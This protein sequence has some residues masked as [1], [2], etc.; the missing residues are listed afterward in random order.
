[1]YLLGYDIGSS[2]VK[3]ALVDAKTRAVID[4]VKYPE[5]EMEIMSRQKGWAEQ[6]PE[7]W[8]RYLCIGTKSILEKN[9]IDAASIESIGISYQMHGLVVV[10]KE[11]QVLR[12]AI[13][14]CDSRAV[15]IGNR[16]FEQMGPDFCLS[17]YQNSPGNFTASKIKW[18]KDN[19]PD[20]Y[21][22][23]YKV[24]LP[25][26]YIAMKL[27]GRISTT[28]SGLSEGILWNFKENRIA[29][30]LL[31]HY[32][33]QHDLIPEVLPTFSQSGKLTA[34]ASKETG[35]SENTIVTYRAGDQPNNALSL[36]VLRPGEVAATSGT[37]GV[38]YGVVDKIVVD[39][40][41]RVNA[42]A[43]VNYSD[44]TKRTGVLLCINGAGIQYSWLKNQVARSNRSYEDMERMVSTVPVGSEG[45][46]MFPYGNGAERIFNNRNLESHILNVEF[47]RH[48]RAH[49]YRAALEG[50]AF[51]FV[52]GIH[53][54]IEMGIK[55]NKMRVGNDNM[56]RSEVFSTTI[57][58]LLNIDL[59]V[60]DTTG[61]VG[62]AL[63]SGHGSGRYDSL[64]SV[65]SSIEPIRTF[66]PAHNHAEYSQAYRF[67]EDNLYNIIN[68][69]SRGKELESQE[70]TEKNKLIAK[71]SLL[72]EEQDRKLN[73]V[74]RGLQ[75]LKTDYNSKDITLMISGLERNVKRVEEISN[76]I[77]LLDNPYIDNL[78]ST[79]P[80]L[81]F[82]ELKMCNFLKLRFTTKEIAEKLS[83]SYRGAE[84]KRYRLRKKMN[85]NKG[86][87]LFT[88]LDS[89]GSK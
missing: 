35:L 43:H 28:I 42:F 23:I 49:L 77:D 20:T 26:D 60:Y 78:K 71:Q 74:I 50:I 33:I 9:N 5:Q 36:N 55:V 7:L 65:L 81:S 30:K 57:A 53:I 4:V 62:A 87:S 72:I 16:A 51:T 84:T 1:M 59:E 21:R 41:S 38:V 39:E 12:P 86:V 24:M 69:T 13:I 10:N 47:N 70:I 82:E 76:H 80:D 17:N 34:E 45:I 3:T 89:V 83:L 73:E 48:T 54:L 61:A 46:L 37:S 58:T 6:Q 79:Y 27:T 67:W 25:G 40:E 18:I 75:S 56:F 44:D 14:W 68:N 15:S 63:A 66:S 88:F 8:W 31:D 29:T 19:E 22:K 85:I 52:Y 11:L 32:Q 64:E 2:S